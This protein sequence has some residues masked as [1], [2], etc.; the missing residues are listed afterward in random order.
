[1]NNKF[2]RLYKDEVILDVKI[3]EV[4]V[5]DSP[6]ATLARTLKL[7]VETLVT[8]ILILYNEISI[9]EVKVRRKCFEV[10]VLV[11]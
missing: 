4:K 7:K 11:I 9:I 5:E 2:F 1:L 10:I 8:R 6:L 3:F